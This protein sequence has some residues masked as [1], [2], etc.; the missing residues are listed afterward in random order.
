MSRSRAGGSSLS[1]F[2]TVLASLRLETT[3]PPVPAGNIA[4]E[5]AKSPA[6]AA[7]ATLLSCFW[8]TLGNDRVALTDFHVASLARK[9]AME[10]SQAVRPREGDDDMVTR[11]SRRYR[12]S[13]ERAA[14]PVPPRRST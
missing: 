3:L 2:L 1:V 9:T 8:S 10:L 14:F 12:G 5:N 4:A 6:L 13:A 7:Q 11:G